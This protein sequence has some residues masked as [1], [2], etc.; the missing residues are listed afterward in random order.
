MP[1]FTYGSAVK[2]RVKHLLT[3]LLSLINGEFDESNHKIDLKW[4]AEDS[5]RP[6]L[7]V[8]TRLTDLELLTEKN[9]YGNLKK[10]NKEQIR[11]TITIL[12]DFLEILEDNRVI[13]QGSQTWHFTLTLWSTNKE[14]NL[15]QFDQAWEI[16]KTKKFKKLEEKFHKNLVTTA[17]VESVNY[18]EISE[19]SVSLDS[20]SAQHSDT[21]FQSFMITGTFSPNK[22][23]EIKATLAHLEKLLR[24][25]CTFTLVPEHN[26]LAVSGTFSQDKK[27]QVKVALMHLEK[28]LLEHCITQEWME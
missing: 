20:P 9:C 27:S 1:R 3:A 5:P 15:K 16:C 18:M 26:S 17:S 19:G 4:Q 28:L 24:N 2:D 11:E 6:K 21:P 13:R 8:R 14:K 23:A 12:R 25:N 7:I 10:L 22:L